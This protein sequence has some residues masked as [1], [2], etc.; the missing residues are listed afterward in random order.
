[1]EST[2]E[3]IEE[4]T[5]AEPT[6]ESVSQVIRS[7][8]ISRLQRR[9]FFLFDVIPL[10]TVVLLIPFWSFLAPRW[11]DLALLV[12]FWFITGIGVTVGM[13]RYF[14]HKSFKTGVPF[15][16]F[17]AI[18]G[19][20]AVVGPVFSWVGLHRRHHELSDREGDPHSPHH[21][22]SDLLGRVRGL[23]HAQLG[24]MREHD[25][26]NPN[27]YVRDWLREGWLVALNRRY[28]IW[29]AL[30]IALPGL[31]AVAYEPTVQ[32][33]IQG[34][35]WGGILRLCIVHHIVSAVNSIC[36][37]I[38]TRRFDTP[39]QSTNVALLAIP[40]LGESW[41]NN[42]HAFQASATFRH[43]WW[44]VDLGAA[45]IRLA[46]ILGLVWD[47]RRSNRSRTAAR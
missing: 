38:G 8:Y 39:E 30:G 27:H 43:R 33:A 21:H 29:V 40:T 28:M 22:G 10:L 5:T 17:L 7:S 18:T 25:Y 15:A 16:G 20:M 42:H 2:A 37:V 41:H 24:W 19:M 31:L 32:S 47:V 14:T 4:R 13:H 46:E 26:P 35:A 11:F 36:H 23:F 3:L 45:V 44:E 6:P 34:M 1:M 9:H 12:M